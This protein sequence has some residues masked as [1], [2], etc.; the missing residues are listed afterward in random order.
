MGLNLDLLLRTL[1]TLF[2]F[3]LTNSVGRDSVLGSGISAPTGVKSKSDIFA[4][5]VFLPTGV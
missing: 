5:D 1:F 2:L 4:C 3:V